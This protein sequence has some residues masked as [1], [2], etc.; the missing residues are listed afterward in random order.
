MNN[1]E[2]SQHN[3][4]P[5]YDNEVE[6]DNEVD[7]ENDVESENDF[8]VDYN[9]VD[10]EN[11]DNQNMNTGQ[12]NEEEFSSEDYPLYHSIQSNDDFAAYLYSAT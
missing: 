2:F 6:S 3:T 4:N 12:D 1:D 10:P 9:Y 8:D 7:P 11:S 5:G